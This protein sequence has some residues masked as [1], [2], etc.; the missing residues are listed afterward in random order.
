MSAENKT[1]EIEPD[2]NTDAEQQPDVCLSL[3][4]L[5]TEVTLPNLNSAD[6][7]IELVNVVLIVK[8]KVV[9][10]EEETFHATAVFLAYL[11][12]NAADPV[13]QAA[14]GRQPAR[15]DQRHR[16]RLG[17]R[18]GP[19][20]K[21]VYLLILHQQHHSALTADWLTRYRRV[22]KPCHLDVW[23]D[24][25]TGRKPSGNLDYES[26]WALTREILRDH[27]SNSFAA[28]A[29]WSYTPTG[30]EIALWDQMELEGRLKRKGYRPWADRR[31]DMF[32]RPATETHADYEARMA[33]RK[34]LNDHY[35][36][37]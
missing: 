10:S 18:I 30:A 34:R 22:W 19:R 8:S 15:L 20:P 4:G 5:D 17:R 6:L 7:P 31:T 23:L 24:A 25:P 13:E 11:Q 26:A 21:I 33:R 32:R 37:E 29:G 2:I 35:H 27:T 28:L 1:I 14:E 12:E 9:L 36:I 16:Q 3:K